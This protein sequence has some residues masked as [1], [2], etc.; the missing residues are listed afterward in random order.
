M[1]SASGRPVRAGRGIQ[2]VLGQSHGGFSGR[3]WHRVWD[4]LD[5]GRNGWKDAFLASSMALVFEVIFGW[6]GRI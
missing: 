3:L 5:V 4:E 6:G 1:R 2:P